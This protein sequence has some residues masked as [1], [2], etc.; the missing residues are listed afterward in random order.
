MGGIPCSPHC[1]GRYY[2]YECPLIGLLA[3]ICYL[4]AI[5]KAGIWCKRECIVL[6]FQ[7][8]DSETEVLVK[9]DVY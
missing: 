1:L 3:F 9:I 6:T 8:H 7:V 5:P 2:Y 4:C